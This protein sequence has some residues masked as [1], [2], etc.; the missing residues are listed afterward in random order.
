M[1]K[2][3]L[4]L[5]NV[6]KETRDIPEQWNAMI[7]TT[8]YKQKGC[9]KMLKYYRGIFLALVISKLFES[10][11]KQ[12]INPDLS[13]VNILQ[14]G[15]RTDRSGTDNVFLMRGC[16]DHYVSCKLPLFI[17]AYD[18]EQAFD[19]LWVEKCI[20]S[21]QNIGVSK[22]MIQLIYNRNKK[23]IVRVKTP[24]G[25]TE[26][27]ETEPIV[28]QGTVLGSTMCSSSTGEYCTVNKGIPVGDLNL[29]SLLFV[30][31]IIDL[32][33]SLIDRQ[34][35]HEQAVIFSKINNLIL[36]GTKCYSM[37]LNVDETPPNLAIEIDGSKFVI[38][39][40]VIVYLGDPFNEKGNNDDLIADRVKRG[41]KA[42]ICIE[43][44]IREAT[45]GTY[46]I[47]VWLL[48]YRA[49]FLST[50]LFNSQAWSCLRTKD[51][52]T[53]QV[54]QQNFLKRI[55]GV[56]SGTPN[57]FIFLELGVLPIEAEIHKRQLMYLHRILKLPPDD[58]VHKMFTNLMVFDLNGEKNWWSSV[59]TLLPK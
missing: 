15:A 55:V 14:A 47:S 10:L 38:T 1:R 4:E 36:S 57:S 12:R 48:L 21:L 22:E 9:K 39:A 2:A 56:S 35:F 59:K 51:I 42:S 28:K 41:I 49:L 44:L 50:V 32:S 8:I 16:V 3:L 58:P 6:V 11:I 7:I 46:E 33:S 45:L 13:K 37:A 26:P 30:D 5:F 40:D 27:F 31:D 43:S 53:L 25:A 23:A 17:T 19:S 34:E 20:L 24:F 54:M 52:A 29:N 18:Y